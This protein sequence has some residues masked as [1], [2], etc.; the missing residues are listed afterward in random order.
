MK[1][2]EIWEICMKVQSV[3][4]YTKTQGTIV[5]NHELLYCIIQWFCSKGILKS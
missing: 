5:I 4:F 1:S 3:G 2:G